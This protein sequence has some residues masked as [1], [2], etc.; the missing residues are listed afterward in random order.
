MAGIQ[1][2]FVPEKR[3]TR[4]VGV[5]IRSRVRHSSFLASPVEIT[6]ISFGGFGAS[7]AAEVRCGDYLSVDLPNIGLV[8][9]RVV[10]S[11]PGR[12]GG[13]FPKAVDVRKCLK[14]LR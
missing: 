6:S 14:P 5:S 13:V 2:P 7:G 4:R 11:E 12:F 3:K 1:D 8:R 9:A 10:W